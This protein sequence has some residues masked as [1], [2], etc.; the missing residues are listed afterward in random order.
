VNKLPHHVDGNRRNTVI[1]QY[2]KW[3]GTSHVPDQV[4]EHLFWST[5][6]NA[7]PL[8][9]VV[10]DSPWQL[11]DKDPTKLKGVT[12]SK[13]TPNFVPAQGSTS[14][15]TSSSSKKRKADVKEEPANKIHK[16]SS[17]IS[18][19]GLN[20]DGDNYSCAYDSLITVLFEIW[21]DNL[22]S[23]NVNANFLK[24]KYLE[25][26][27]KGFVMVSQGNNTLENVRD[28]IRKLLHTKNKNLFCYGRV[29]TSLSDLALEIFRSSVNI[30]HSQEQCTNCDF[31]ANRREDELGSVFVLKAT[32][33]LSTSHAL[34]TFGYNS[35]NS[36]P[37]CLA[38][39]RV[40]VFYTYFPSILVFDHTVYF[41]KPSKDIK[42]RGD[43]NKVVHYRLRGLLY[44]G[45]FHFTSRILSLDGDVWYH[46]GMQTG[47]KFVS[48]GHRK[49]MSDDDWQKC[50]GRKLVMSIYMKIS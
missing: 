40:E 2:Q 19:T 16:T 20:W 24:S 1:R 18:P 7:M 25:T 41:I 31:T 9:S 8:L 6:K 27:G 50:K 36:C 44:F 5:Q 43:D 15:P 34:Q 38:N 30:S 45:S 17:T 47:D 14:L 33:T 4:N 22:F 26:L 39:M 10:T 23:W 12:K 21:K 49:F 29:G 3:K 46:D 35:A 32:S 11:L 37:M 28:D 48:H 13:A 42:F